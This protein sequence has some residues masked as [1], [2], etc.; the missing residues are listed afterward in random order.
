MLGNESFQFRFQGKIKRVRWGKEEKR[1]IDYNNDITSLIFH[2]K[3]SFHLLLPSFWI[4]PS[5][6]FLDSW[7]QDRD[8]ERG[9][10]QKEIE[11]EKSWECLKLQHL[12]EQLFNTAIRLSF[13]E[14]FLQFLVPSGKNTARSFDFKCSLFIQMFKCSL[15]FSPFSSLH[16]T[17]KKEKERKSMHRDGAQMEKGPS[18]YVHTKYRVY[19]RTWIS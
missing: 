2:I 14:Q 9:R 16:S 15:F 13:N 11:M 18:P 19:N 10:T 5:L 17:P 1:V 4:I 8:G 12:C 3:I 6:R 7:S